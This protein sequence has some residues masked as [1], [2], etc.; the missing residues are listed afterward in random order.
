[1]ERAAT[2]AKTVS[3]VVT[4]AAASSAAAAKVDEAEATKPTGRI[5][6]RFFIL[7]NDMFNSVQ[8]ADVLDLPLFSHFL[9][10]TLV[11]FKVIL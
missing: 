10:C 5:Y 6:F 7:F 4:R 3:A 1:M 8:S 11:K 9:N 2:V